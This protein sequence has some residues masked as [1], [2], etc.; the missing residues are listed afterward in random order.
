MKILLIEGPGGNIAPYEAHLNRVC[1]NGRPEVQLIKLKQ[2]S[3]LEVRKA[4]SKINGSICDNYDATNKFSL[5]HCYL[6]A[7]EGQ[8]RL[9]N[10]GRL[11]VL[12]WCGKWFAFE[13]KM[14]QFSCMNYQVVWA[15]LDCDRMKKEVSVNQDGESDPGRGNSASTGEEEE[16]TKGTHGSIITFASAKGQMKPTNLHSPFADRIAQYFT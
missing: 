12:L 9:D 16:E 8:T 15:V 11:E 4:I 13:A 3:R 6:S 10:Q 5:V 7:G 14:R 2:K 1:I